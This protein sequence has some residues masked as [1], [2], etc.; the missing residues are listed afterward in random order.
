[1]SKLKN[2]ELYSLENNL[3]VV[4]MFSKDLNLKYYK[5]VKLNQEL[6]T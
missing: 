3:N 6:A 1:M 2:K 5:V 4:E